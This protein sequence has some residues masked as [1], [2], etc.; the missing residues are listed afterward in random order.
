MAGKQFRLAQF[1][2]SECPPPFESLSLTAMHV[3]SGVCLL[4]AVRPES[5]SD[6]AASGAKHC[7]Q[8]PQAVGSFNAS[9]GGHVFPLPGEHEEHVQSGNKTLFLYDK[10][11]NTAVFLGTL[12]FY[13]QTFNTRAKN[14]KHE[15]LN[16]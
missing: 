5:H 14:N 8:R 2:L 12:I 11:R 7:L 6:D 4:A 3:K 16:N 10:S 13:T 15:S 9:A 1:T